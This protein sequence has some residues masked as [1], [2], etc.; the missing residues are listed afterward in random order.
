MERYLSILEELCSLLEELVQIEQI[1]LEAARKKRFTGIESCMKQEQAAVLKLRGLEQ[2]REQAQEQLGFAEKTF[3]EILQCANGEQY[4]Q[5]APVYQRLSSGLELFRSVSK[6]C[7][8]M[9]SVNL[10]EIEQKLSKDKAAGTYAT[11][12]S[13]A[14]ESK[15]ITDWRV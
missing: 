1:K 10:H 6:S 7:A 9:I 8:D 3:K 4:R 15:H 12:G 5:L 11:D 14:K 2:Q 13:M